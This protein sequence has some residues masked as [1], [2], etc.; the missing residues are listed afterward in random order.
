VLLLVVLAVLAGQ[1]VYS[2]LGG[3][4]LYEDFHGRL[5]RMADSAA[6]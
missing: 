6:N 5:G 1:I 2:Q 4:L 3:Y